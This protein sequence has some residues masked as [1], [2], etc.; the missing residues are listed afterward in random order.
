MG[1]AVAIL[2]AQLGPGNLKRGSRV[3]T[4]CGGPVTHGPGKIV[5]LNKKMIMRSHLDI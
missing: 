3:I 1:V 2:E 5:D 4:F